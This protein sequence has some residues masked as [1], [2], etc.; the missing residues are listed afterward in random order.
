MQNQNALSE[1][2]NKL[3]HIASPKSY[4]YKITRQLNEWSYR[5][6]PLIY[7]TTYYMPVRFG[8][9][10][11]LSPKK[12]LFIE[13]AFTGKPEWYPCEKNLHTFKRALADEL[14]LKNTTG[15]GSIPVIDLTETA[16]MCDDELIEHILATADCENANIKR[17][18]A[19]NE[20]SAFKDY[21]RVNSS[22]PDTPEIAVTGF[23]DYEMGRRIRV[24]AQI[25]NQE[26]E[27]YGFTK[28]KIDITEG[29]LVW[30]EKSPTYVCKNVKWM[31]IDGEEINLIDIA[32][33]DVIPS[34]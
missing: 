6:I 29:M 18:I 4:L 31:D 12:P 22:N 1:P 19:L 15:M 9:N 30:F 34:K 17:H 7:Q 11:E 5:T 14:G 23:T 3:M 20:R 33:I 13:T 32:K 10:L 8:K 28:T 21:I 16:D 25:R 2:A 26:A 24:L 27:H